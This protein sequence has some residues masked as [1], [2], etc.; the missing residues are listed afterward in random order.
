MANI[1]QSYGGYADIDS[2]M[3][4][5]KRPMADIASASAVVNI[6]LWRISKLV[7]RKSHRAMAKIILV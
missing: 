5:I 6:G 1:T 3:A 2:L 7:W 4:T